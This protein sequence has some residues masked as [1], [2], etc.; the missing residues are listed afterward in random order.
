LGKAFKEKKTYLGEGVNRLQEPKKGF[1]GKRG[2]YI[3]KRMVL[4]AD[5]AE[6]LLEG[7]RSSC[8][9]REGNQETNRGRRLKE[10]G[11]ATKG[12]PLPKIAAGQTESL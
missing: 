1:E 9:S 3:L 2:T 8:I 4:T 10:M 7:R 12:N 5:R 11:Y 6:K